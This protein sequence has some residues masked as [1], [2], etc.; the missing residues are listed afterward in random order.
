MSDMETSTRLLDVGEIA[1]R[2]GISR[3]EVF[4]LMFATRELPVLF[5]AHTHG[6]PEDAVEAY[7][8]AHSK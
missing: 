8:R 4:D 2:L 7:R 6:V 1:D 3:E 5:E